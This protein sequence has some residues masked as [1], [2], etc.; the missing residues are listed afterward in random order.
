MSDFNIDRMIFLFNQCFAINQGWGLVLKCMVNDGEK[1]IYR[2]EII[3]PNDRIVR[4]AEAMYSYDDSENPVADAQID[5]VETVLYLAG[6]VVP[7]EPEEIEGE[8]DS[9]EEDDEEKAEEENKNDGQKKKELN[10]KHRK[11]GFYAKN[12]VKEK[13]LSILKAMIDK[14]NDLSDEKLTIEDVARTILNKDTIE[15]QNELDTVME[16]INDQI[17]LIEDGFED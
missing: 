6:I 16:W 8:D 1:V 14:Y 11:K 17:N 5:C 9:D 10:L 13:A 3:D 2:A 12:K 15:T 7:A 4:S